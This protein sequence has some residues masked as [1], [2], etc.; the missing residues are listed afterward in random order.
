[1]TGSVLKFDGFLKVY[2]E[3]KDTKD[4]EDEALS[5]RLP[6]LNDGEALELKELKPEQH[7]TEPPPRFNEASLVKELEERGIG[8]PSTY[9]SIINTIQD[10]EYVVKRAAATGRFLSD[11][12][13]QVVSDL[14]VKNFPYIFDTA[15]TAKLEEELDEI[16][17]GKEK[18]T[19]LLSGFYGHFE[20]ELE[21]AEKNMEN[22]KRMEEPTDEKCDA[23]RVSAGVEVGQVRHV[24][25][26]QRVRQEGQEQLH[27]HQGEHC[28]QAG[29]ARLRKAQEAG[30]EEYC[31]NCGRVMVLRDGPL[32]PFMAALDIARIRRARRFAS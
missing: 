1:M 20:K 8:R 14:L 22:I 7:F 19:D 24:L 17:E 12:N 26:L 10:R 30:E 13:R 27:V 3:S 25:C 6:E 5:N 9:A 23:L 32:G 2:E 15:Y 18:W 16:E 4:D 21:V 31:E 29:P 11:G 28:G